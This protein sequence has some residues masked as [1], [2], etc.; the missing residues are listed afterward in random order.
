ML[1]LVS[2]EN[3]R[4][5]NKKIFTFQVM[6][7]PNLD[8]NTHHSLHFWVKGSVEVVSN[9][10]MVGVRKWDLLLVQ[11]G[12]VTNISNLG[13]LD[14]QDSE[15]KPNHTQGTKVT[16]SG[17]LTTHPIYGKVSRPQAGVP[18][19]GIMAFTTIKLSLTITMPSTFNLSSWDNSVS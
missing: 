3:G 9:K 8:K 12:L 2:G 15:T 18:N 16:S 17:N 11:P 7:L 1:Q 6:D 4:E 13:I 10:H 14:T 19:L 5:F